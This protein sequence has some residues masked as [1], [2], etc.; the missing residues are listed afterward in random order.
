MEYS[1]LGLFLYIL[2]GPIIV[3]SMLCPQAKA[4]RTI[5]EA[6]SPLNENIRSLGTDLRLY[7]I[8]FF[9]QCIKDSFNYEMKKS[10]T[11][12]LHSILAC[13]IF[14]D[15]QAPKI[16]SGNSCMVYWKMLFMEVE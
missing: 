1:L 10:A 11:K 13:F 7:M 3:D 4:I 15:L 8:Y 2:F 9:P 6:M 5:M 16:F 12:S 14:N